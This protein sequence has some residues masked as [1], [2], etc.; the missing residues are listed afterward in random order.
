MSRQGKMAKA[1][2]TIAVRLGDRSIEALYRDRVRS[3]RTRSY[4]LNAPA[5][6][7]SIEIQKTLLGTELKIGRR[8]LLCP[9]IATA[10]FLAIFA[11]LGVTEVA[12]P[13]DITQ[14]DRLAEV[15]EQARTEA[16]ALID[17]ET[18][19]MSPQARGRIRQAWIASQRA[20]IAA[21]GAGPTM[22]QFDQSTKQRR[23][24]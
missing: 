15:F 3:L 6:P 17:D 4:P 22:P 8:R 2:E 21:A 19:G 11:G 18:A 16:M 23:R 20:A 10:R 13:Y 9:D 24:R 1:I 5:R 14:I 12:V 7:T